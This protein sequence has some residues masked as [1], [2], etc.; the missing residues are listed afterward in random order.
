[1]GGMTRDEEE[2]ELKETELTL[3]LPGAADSAQRTSKRGFSEA[4]NAFPDHAKWAE[5]SDVE[6]AKSSQQRGASF[7][8]KLTGSSVTDD[9]GADE[10]NSPPDSDSPPPKAR[11][12]GWPPLKTFQKRVTLTSSSFSS[13]VPL[14][15][16]TSNVNLAS[17][18]KS[19]EDAL[20]VK[21]LMDGAPYLRK[22]DLKMYSSYQELVA[23]L[24][25]MITTFT[26]GQGG[27][28]GLGGGKLMNGSTLV[29]TYEDKDGDWMLVGDVPWEMFLDSCKKLRIMKGSDAIGLAPRAIEKN[30]T[31]T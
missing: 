26:M 21:V 27:S 7:P 14:P 28:L 8:A 16:T 23:A 1:M 2:Q 17:G 6:A 12:V 11:A 29:T 19:R 30:K 15:S 20:F 22:M 10:D 5:F 13:K 3:G 18:S 25:K 24:E 9:R 4:L 31:R